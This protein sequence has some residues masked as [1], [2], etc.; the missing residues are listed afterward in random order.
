LGGDHDTH[1][2]PISLADAKQ[3][4]EDRINTL[5]VD[6]GLPAEDCNVILNESRF[7]T[8]WADAQRVECTRH[9]DATIGR[10][11]DVSR[12]LTHPDFDGPSGFFGTV[13]AL[14]SELMSVYLLSEW[15][16]PSPSDRGR[17]VDRSLL[18]AVAGYKEQLLASR[19]KYFA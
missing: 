14:I 8:W 13:A 1:I 19:N 11:G 9:V 18:G 10:G 5:S 15:A 12:L 7:A 16:G 2:G 4:V 17:R 3:D 6:A